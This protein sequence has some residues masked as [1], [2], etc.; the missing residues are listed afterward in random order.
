MEGDHREAIE[1]VA[2]ALRSFFAAGVEGNSGE[3]A[4]RLMQLYI[5]ISIGYMHLLGVIVF[6]TYR[7]EGHHYGSVHPT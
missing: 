4:S 2:E 1:I 7:G 3:L 5:L 6:L